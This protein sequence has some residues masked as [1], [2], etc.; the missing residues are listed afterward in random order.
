M[1]DHVT[2]RV[3]DLDRARRFYTAVLAALGH[4]PPDRDQWDD[5]ALYEADAEHPATR[6]VHVG[7]VA[8]SREAVDAFWRTGVALGH[9]DDG[10]PGPRTVYGPGYYGGFLLD[11]PPGAPAGAPANSVEA[12]RHG[13]LRQDGVVDHVWL[14]VGD[15][16]AARA[17]WETI[18]PHAGLRLVAE[19]EDRVRFADAAGRGGSISL[20]ADGRPCSEHLHIAFGAEDDA[21][22]DAFHAAAL[23]AGYRDNGAPGLRPAY[24]AGYYGA[25]VLDP[26]GHNVEVVHHRPR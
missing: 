1:I 21:T 6:G 9:P 7:L 3:P 17:F 19:L 15:L 4:G 18:A 20:V 13:N 2:L 12:V 25:F 11:R 5:F 24:H 10:A 16:A 26:G 22:V 8:P 23:A 14:R